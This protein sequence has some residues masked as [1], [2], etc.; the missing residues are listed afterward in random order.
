MIKLRVKGQ[1]SWNKNLVK[2][3]KLLPIKRY[4]AFRSGSLVALTQPA[5]LNELNPRW[6]V[7]MLVTP[8]RVLVSQHRPDAEGLISILKCLKAKSDVLSLAGRVLVELP[9]PS[10]LRSHHKVLPS[11]WQK[12]PSTSCLCQTCRT[13]SAQQGVLLLDP[14]VCKG[15]P[16]LMGRSHLQGFT[17]RGI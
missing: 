9:R 14:S 6:R 5:Q 2:G 12:S 15:H 16:H 8:E 11:W 1:K 10:A 7:S 13:R 3:N 4:F 17:I